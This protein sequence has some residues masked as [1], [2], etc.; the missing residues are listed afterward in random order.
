[1]KYQSQFYIACVLWSIPLVHAVSNTCES[2]SYRTVSQSLLK[3]DVDLPEFH[4][5]LTWRGQ[6]FLVNSFGA[7]AQRLGYHHYIH[8][9]SIILCNCTDIL[10]PVSSVICICI[11]NCYILL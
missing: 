4:I 8:Y 11:T 5:N 10:G 9:I 6:A 1:M 7:N 3:R 2:L